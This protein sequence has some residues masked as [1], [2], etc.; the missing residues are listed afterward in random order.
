M[1]KEIRNRIPSDGEKMEFVE[2]DKKKEVHPGI[3]L[4]KFF[5][6]V[7]ETAKAE[8]LFVMKG[9]E[10]KVGDDD[11]NFVE[12]DDLPELNGNEEFDE[13]SVKLDREARKFIAEE[14]KAGRVVTYMEALAVAKKRLGK[15]RSHA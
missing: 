5:E 11:H 2:G 12:D 7:I 15:K 1:F 10:A 9:E 3:Y 8:K 6:K 13:D 4:E 14:R